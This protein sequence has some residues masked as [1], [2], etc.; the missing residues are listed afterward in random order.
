MPTTHYNFPTINGTDTIDGVNAINGLANA[1]DAALYNVESEQQSGLP[2]ASTITTAMLQNQSVTTE[3]LSSTVQTQLSKADQAATDAATASN[4]AQSALTTANQ[5][6]AAFNNAPTAA[7]VSISGARV[8][9]WGRI[10]VVQYFEGSKQ[11]NNGAN[12]L[13][14]L[15]SG[16]RPSSQVAAPCYTANESCNAYL[17]VTANGT[18]GV[19]NGGTSGATEVHGSIVF[20]EGL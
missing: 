5:A 15:P 13:G 4:N 20:F 12:D 2:G 17:Y 10:V 7:G 3:K 11:L 1:V 19:W 18:I 14:T 16:Y 8:F 9:K 6:L